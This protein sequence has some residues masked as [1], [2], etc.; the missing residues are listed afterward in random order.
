MHLGL[1][2]GLPNNPT[3]NVEQGMQIPSSS[4]SDI[5]TKKDIKDR[6]TLSTGTSDINKPPPVIPEESD[7][8]H[9]V[10]L[11]QIQKAV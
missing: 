1:G 11:H 10:L 5:P 6:Q 8:N 4:I 9:H 7:K 3:K 2:K